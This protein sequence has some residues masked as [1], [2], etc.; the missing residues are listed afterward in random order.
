M[1]IN[2]FLLALQFLTILPI[3]PLLTD[4]PEIKRTVLWFVIIGA[5][6]GL[7]LG[8]T[9]FLGGLLFH[10]DL[11]LALVLLV[12][13]ISNGGFHLD[14]LA[15]T[16]DGLAVKS[17]GNIEEDISKRL[18]V[19]K[20]P[21]LGYAGVAAIVLC[22]GLKYLLLKNISHLTYSAYYSAILFMPMISKWAMV[23]AMFN[24]KPAR[25]DGL[26]RLFIGKI[27]F[28][29]IIGCTIFFLGIAIIFTMIFKRYF[30]GHQLFFYPALLAG[31]YGFIR[32]LVRN[33]NKKFNGLTGDNLGAINE[34]SEIIF[35]FMV[36]I[37]QRLF[38]S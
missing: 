17:S 16:F 20:D 4:E 26:G 34:L 8:I 21:A 22:L 37:W 31:I 19:M 9:D 27:F 1:G 7:V 33:F 30:P 35:L 6:Q 38:I 14:G 2:G 15:D 29:D 32:Y 36:I 11:V 23:I 12:L 24:T 28:K 13:V 5:L 25:P 10:Q 18:S 3:R